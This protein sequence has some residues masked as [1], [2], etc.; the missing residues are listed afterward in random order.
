[1]RD[2]E[3]SKSWIA[4]AD[5]WTSVVRDRRIESRR[6]ATDAAI[7]SAVLDQHP[8]TVL[9]LGCGEGWLARALAGIDATGIDGSPALVEAAKRL[10]GGEFH[11]I[12]YRELASLN[13]TFDV[14]VANFSLFEEDLHDVL[15]SVPAPTLIVQTAHPSFAA[16]DGWQVETF[17]TFEGEFREPMPW[18]F[19][20]AA[21]WGTTFE[22]A[23]YGV[24]ETREQVHP[25]T[26]KPLSMI[27]IVRR[28]SRSSRTGR[29]GRG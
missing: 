12:S 9:D 21:S 27:W 26:G 7:V 28:A 16:E 2:D 4:N 17:A 11:A 3:I 23:G 10:G 14:A 13:G 20:T 25:E 5:A 6:V 1:M 8:R 24:A 15:T 18:Y 22:D 19:R 29:P